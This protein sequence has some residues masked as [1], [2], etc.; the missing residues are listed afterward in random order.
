MLSTSIFNKVI[1]KTHNKIVG[2]AK[3]YA[4]K[5][6]DEF[7]QTIG[8]PFYFFKPCSGVINATLPHAEP[9]RVDS[10]NEVIPEI[11]LGLMISKTA[12]NIKERR[13]RDYIG[14][15]FLCLDITDVGELEKDPQALAL[16]KGQDTH[17][18]LGNFIHA[19]DID[20][21]HNLTLN[22]EVNNKPRISGNTGEMIYRI[23]KILSMVSSY[24]T[25]EQGDMILTGSPLPPGRIYSGDHL[26]A[27]MFSG[28]ELLDE[29][30]LEVEES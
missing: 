28:D 20:D 8:S 17:T 10:H 25:L 29:F 1:G 13:W 3:N 15:Y 9:I 23:P 5:S 18:P 24:M 6:S 27:Q 4:V 7:Y 14:G 11:E 30:S 16:C 22:L 26:T 19:A 2:V 21:P 12:K